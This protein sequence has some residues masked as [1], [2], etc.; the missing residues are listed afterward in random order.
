MCSRKL[1]GPVRFLPFRSGGGGSIGIFLLA[2][3]LGTILGSG[4]PANAQ[5]PA[6]T[7][8]GRD[9]EV[10]FQVTERGDML[11]S[12]RFERGRIPTEGAGTRLLW[13]PGKAA[14]RAGRVGFGMSEGTEW[15]DAAVGAYSAAV[16]VN[17]RAS[18]RGG[19]ALGQG[20]AAA[21]N[22]SFAAGYRTTARGLRSVAFGDMT[23]GRGNFSTA[24]GVNT[25]AGASASVALGRWNVQ[26]GAPD[27][28][29]NSDPLLMAGN[30]SG[31]TDRSN[32]LLLRKNGD[33]TISG[34]LTE[35][36]DQRLK[37]DI[38]ALD[39]VADALGRI[40]PVRFR[41][42]AETGHPTEPQIGLLAQDVQTEFPSLVTEGPQGR[43]SLAYP[44]LT[45]V[46]LKGFQEQGSRIDSLRRRL[47]RVERLADRQ[48]E[49]AEQVAALQANGTGAAPLQVGSLG[50]MVGTG[51]LLLCVGGLIGAALG[52][53]W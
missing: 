16:G 29:R 38:E 28:W 20:T 12:G 33:L 13:H 43:L 2:F 27:T 42:K 26:R 22:Q 30:G 51:L 34:T 7:V 21:G 9:G 45:A 1:I 23:R 14:F 3:F 40:P 49:L 47:S 19:V 36:S 15:D 52:R 17:T 8:T 48:N 31:P 50:G 25:T 35:H 32:A 44:R 53:R 39:S 24:L 18:G 6:E 4:R 10:L 46:L 41:F 11:A 5:T 37:T